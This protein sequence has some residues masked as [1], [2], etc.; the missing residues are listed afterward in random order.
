MPGYWRKDAE[1]QACLRDGWVHSGDAG[2]TDS[3]G[4]L[5]IVDRLKDMIVTGG[6]NVYA[7]EVE[8]VLSL[9]PEIAEVAVIAVPDERW[10]ERVH[11]VVVP[12]DNAVITQEAIIGFCNDR[13]ADYKKPR[14]VE[15]RVEPLPLSGA[16]KIL[17]N[18]LRSPH[19]VGRTRGVN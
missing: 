10:G 15:I 3:D 18:V 9:M 7:A 16:G 13:I 14:S 12:R 8:S 19:W 2:Y 11:A 1:T 17:K 6:E 4:L 5:F